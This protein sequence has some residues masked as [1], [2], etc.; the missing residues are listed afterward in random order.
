MWGRGGPGETG[1]EQLRCEG[2]MKRERMLLSLRNRD[3]GLTTSPSLLAAGLHVIEWDMLLRV[4]HTDLHRRARASQSSS[5]PARWKPS[6]VSAQTVNRS[7]RSISSAEA[8]GTGWA[9]R[10]S[11]LGGSDH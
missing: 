4:G 3:K 8:L 2:I 1:S 10:L 5:D 7:K 6:C 11:S 9:I